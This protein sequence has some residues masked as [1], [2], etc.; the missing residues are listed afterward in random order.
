MREGQM[1][2]GFG[3]GVLEGSPGEE[4]YENVNSEDT[5]HVSKCNAIRKY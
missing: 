1:C 5:L 4:M 2:A 3:T